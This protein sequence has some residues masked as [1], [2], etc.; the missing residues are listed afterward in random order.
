MGDRRIV[1]L[2]PATKNNINK[3]SNNNKNKNNKNTHINKNKAPP[4]GAIQI[5]GDPMHKAPPQGAIQILGEIH[6]LQWNVHGWN[7]GN[8]ALLQSMDKSSYDVMCLQEFMVT[9]ESEK[10]I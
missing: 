7:Y 6:I 8:E 2:R 3:N 9:Y 5:L 1:R 10:V 4:Q